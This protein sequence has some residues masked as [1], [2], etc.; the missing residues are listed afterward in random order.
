MTKAGPSNVLNDK[1]PAPESS[2]AKKTLQRGTPYHMSSEYLVVIIVLDFNDIVNECNINPSPYSRFKWICPR[3]ISYLSEMWRGRIDYV[4]SHQ[5]EPVFVGNPDVPDQ[6]IVSASKGVC[7]IDSN[8]IFF[9]SLI[10]F[11]FCY[12]W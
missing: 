4:G 5:K 9:F 3:L 6:K 2:K 11:G 12:I 10:Y 7:I 8:S 1:L